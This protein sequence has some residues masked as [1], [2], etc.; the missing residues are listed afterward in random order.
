MT[1]ARPTVVG[2]S[3]TSTTGSG[4]ISEA[5]TNNTNA[6]INVTYVYTITAN[7]CTN[8][9]NVVVVVKPT[10][11]IANKTQTICTGTAFTITPVNNAPT[12]IVPANTVYTWTVANNPTVLGE[13]AGTSSNGSISQVLTNPTSAPSTV[14]Y[15]VTP[16]INGCT[17]STF[18]ITVVVNPTIS[19]A[20]VNTT[21]C[22]GST[23][24]ITPVDGA[25]TDLVPNVTLYT[26]SI[27]PNAAIAGGSNQTTPQVNVSQTLANNAASTQQLVYT[28]TPQYT[29]AGLTCTG[30]PFTIT[31][32][33]LSGVPSVNVGADQTI[34]QNA[35]A[36]YAVSTVSAETG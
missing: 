21:I 26:W 8:T 13:T 5:L 28:V 14:V 30:T 9:N 10:P 12:E 24:A 1:W 32:N 19:V 25:L 18:T 31:V 3:P 34:C 20:N 15:T 17:G 2:I 23:F 6:S 35:T 16:S 33:V 7:G 27:T 4:N 11:V 36:A 22:T 29:N